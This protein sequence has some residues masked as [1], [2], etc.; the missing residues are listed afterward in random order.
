MYTRQI[1]RASRTAFIIALDLS[2]SMSDDTL[3]IRDARTK[4]DALSVIVNELLNELIARARRSDRVRDYYDIAVIGY[5]G[6]GI[7]PLLSDEWFI[8]VDRLERIQPEWRTITSETVDPNGGTMYTKVRR[9]YWIDPR[10]EGRTSL[11]EV[12]HKIYELTDSW[13]KNPAHADSFPPTIFNITDGEA[14]DAGESEIR[15]ICDRI[16][17]LG[18]SDGHALMFNVHLWSHDEAPAV[19]FPT[20][21]DRA[22]LGRYGQLLFDC[23]S[24]IPKTLEARV[25]EIARPSERGPFRAMSYNCSPTK[26]LAI[27]AIGSCSVGMQ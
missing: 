25:R 10:P 20:K 18:T 5:S 4:A 21:R 24:Q 2:G 13:C 26:A 17:Q 23:S 16:R 9:P 12:F 1:S 3:A 14:S 19:L 6:R 11:C 27:L 8:S 7:E 22:S 15:D